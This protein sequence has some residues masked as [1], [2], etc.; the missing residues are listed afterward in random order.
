MINEETY[1][2]LVD[3]KMHGLARSFR[4]HLDGPAREDALTFEERFGQMI[5]IEWSD[6]E[7]KRLKTRITKSKLREYACVEDIDYAHPRGLDRSVMQRLASC[8]WVRECEN[9]IITGISGLGK[10]WLSCAL[11][12]KACRDGFTGFYSRTP[13]LLEEIYIARGAGTYGKTIDKLAKPDI[14]V[15]DDFGLS[16]LG[17]TERRDLLE[18]VE[19]RHG[20]RSTIIASQIAVK[21]WHEIIGEPTVADAILD[22]LVSS[23]HRIDLKGK[24]TMRGKKKIA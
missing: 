17:D 7:N 5:D 24:Q 11:V 18:I 1:K 14:L 23:A 9:L 3:M 21:H 16:P 6:R 2:K 10:T 22:R 12:H 19:A 20:K 8:K 4:E 15:L 13:R